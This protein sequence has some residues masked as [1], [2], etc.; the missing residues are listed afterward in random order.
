MNFFKI[1]HKYNDGIQKNPILIIR[2]KKRK[3][4]IITGLKLLSFPLFQFQF[5]FSTFSI[6]NSYHSPLP[7]VQPTDIKKKKKQKTNKNPFI[8][9]SSYQFPPTKENEKH[10]RERKKK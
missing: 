8:D 2:N 1:F 7:I 9:Y 10:S 3:K 6:S 5:S 4:Y